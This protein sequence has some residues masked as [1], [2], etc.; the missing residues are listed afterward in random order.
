MDTSGLHF[1]ISQHSCCSKVAQFAPK[2]LAQFTPKL[3]AQFAPNYTHDEEIIITVILR[4][5]R[6]P[7]E[8]DLSAISLLDRHTS[9]DPAVF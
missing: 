4:S 3:V 1:M 8:A 9:L 6:A 2:S 5:N 7:S